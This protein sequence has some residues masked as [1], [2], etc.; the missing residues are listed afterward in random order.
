MKR[1]IEKGKPAGVS[2]V[3]GDLVRGRVR[4]TRT[5][6]YKVKPQ[7]HPRW[8]EGVRCAGGRADLKA[9]CKRILHRRAD[10][11]SEGDGH[12]TR[13]GIRSSRYTTRE[14]WCS[15]AKFNLDDE[16]DDEELPT[17]T[18]TTT[19]DG[20]SAPQQADVPHLMCPRPFVGPDGLE[21][22]SY[23][24]YRPIKKPAAYRQPIGRLRPP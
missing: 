12:E 14:A 24:R 8:L 4:E 11:R 3:S 15:A 22:V 10:H 23:P 17:M 2:D 9:D 19:T 1:F 16:G 5:T 13:I 20:H 21:L 6:G 7:V 18:T